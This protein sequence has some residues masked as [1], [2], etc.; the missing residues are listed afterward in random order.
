MTQ[1]KGLGRGG[2]GEAPKAA[3]EEGRGESMYLPAPALWRVCPEAQLPSL[4]T[5]MAG[6]G[7]VWTKKP[8]EG[9]ALRPV[10]VNLL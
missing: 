7:E 8:D 3:R 4:L 6:G 2:A 1:V 10:S 9:L 5:A